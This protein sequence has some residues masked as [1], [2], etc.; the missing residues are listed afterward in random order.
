MPKTATPKRKAKVITLRAKANHAFL[1]QAQGST[2]ANTTLP[3]GYVVPKAPKG[4]VWR[5]KRRSLY[6]EKA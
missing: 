6:L 4:K 3:N 2:L 5:V 1:E